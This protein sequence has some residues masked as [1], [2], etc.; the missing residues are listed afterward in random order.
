MK[1]LLKGNFSVTA[2]S[3]TA[4][5]AGAAVAGIADS[6]A[7][8]DITLPETMAVSVFHQIDSA[9]AVMGDI[10]RTKWSRLPELRIEFTGSSTQ[11]DSVTTLNLEDSDRY[12]LG[13]LYTPGGPWIYRAGIA[14]DQTPTPSEDARPVR[15]PDAD[16]TWLSFGAGYRQ[17]DKLSFDFAYTHIKFDEAKIRKSANPGSENFLR[18]NL[19]GD[20]RTNIHVLSAQAQWMF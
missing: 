12:A 18:G 19:V 1:Y 15:L 3:A 11:D 20:Y 6:G 9:W 5:A 13:A 17:S 10:T 7:Q 8:A 14:F 4:A 2:P 16:R